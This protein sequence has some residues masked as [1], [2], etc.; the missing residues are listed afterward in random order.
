MI[1]FLRFNAYICNNNSCHIFGISW[2][3]MDKNKVGSVNKKSLNLITLIDRFAQK[4]INHRRNAYD[5]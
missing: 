3:G 2:Q 1:D 4:Q 5:E